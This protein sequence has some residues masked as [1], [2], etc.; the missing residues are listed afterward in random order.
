MEGRVRTMQMFIGIAAAAGLMSWTLHAQDTGAASL[1]MLNMKVIAL[2]QQV[3]T[4]QQKVAA[5]EQGRSRI[6]SPLEVVDAAGKVAVRISAATNG[7][8]H[9][10]V[11]NNAGQTG[12]AVSGDGNVGVFS[13]GSNV[14]VLK[15]EANGSGAVIVGEGGQ[16]IAVM[17]ADS[18]NQGSLIL[19]DAQGRPGAAMSGTGNIGVLYGGNPV[20]G[21]KAEGAAR[22]AFLVGDGQGKHMARLS[23]DPANPTAGLLQL[24]DSSS[25][26]IFKVTQKVAKGDARVGVGEIEGRYAVMVTDGS[27]KPLVSMG[28]AKVGG[29]AVAA[30]NSA[31]PIGA[32]LSGTGQIHVAD[33]SG[34]SLATMVAE[35][36]QGAFSIRNKGGTTIV[37]LSEGQ[38]GGLL[39]LANNGG[40]AMVEGGVLGGRGIV[41]AYPL[42]HPG[43]GFVGMPGTFISGIIK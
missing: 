5:L 17:T 25:K 7:E 18:A 8:G 14:A 26:P 36:G 41:R 30:Y 13:G 19:N 11:M 34:N 6:R 39:Q 32:I 27:G 10:M 24:N 29:G 37:R 4:L 35:N 42:G 43:M 20:A 15:A 33:P 23:V 38:D 2:T 28:E 9:I 3:T 31:G 22:G 1:E 21:M 16:R 40:N 12:V